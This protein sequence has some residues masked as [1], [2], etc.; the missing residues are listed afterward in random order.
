MSQCT[1]FPRNFLFILRLL[2]NFFGAAVFVL[3]VAS[4]VLLPALLVDPSLG[5]FSSSAEAITEAAGVDVEEDGV[6]LEGAEVEASAVVALSAE[7]ELSP[8]GWSTSAVVVAA[9]GGSEGSRGGSV[10]GCSCDVDDGVASAAAV[11]S[12]LLSCGSA[13]DAATASPS[14]A[15]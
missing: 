8:G 4:V 15:A 3:E 13:L 12:V 14:F 2:V 1:Y 6:T 5:A 10:G 7:A 11:E 9:C